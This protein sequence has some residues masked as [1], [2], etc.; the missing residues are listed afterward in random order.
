MWELDLLLTYL[1]DYFF[2]LSRETLRQYYQNTNLR[3]SYQSSGSGGKIKLS[4]EFK[5]M[6]RVEDN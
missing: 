5:V 2:F 6:Q 1:I 3:A 4:L